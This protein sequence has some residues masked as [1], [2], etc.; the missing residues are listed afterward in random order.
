VSRTANIRPIVTNTFEGASTTVSISK[1]TE[2]R[3][4]V[5]TCMLWEREFYREGAETANRIRLLASNLPFEKVADLALEAREQY[6]LRHVPLWLLVSLIDSGHKGNQVSEAIAKVI[7]RPDEMSELL[8]L[9]WKDGKKPLTKQLKK[10]LAKA[11]KKFN[12]YSLAKFDK[13][14]A[15]S[16]RD[17]MFLSHPCPDSPE[18]EALFKRVANKELKTPDTWETQLSAGA[19]KGETFVRLIG[20]QKLGPQAM[21]KNLRNMINANVGS[22]AIRMGLKNVKTDRV[23]P[24]EFI[25]AA[26]CA[27]QFEPELEELMFKCLAG[28]SLKGKTTLLIDR[29]GSM[30][31]RLSDK[32]ELTRYDAAAGLAMLLREES[33][34]IRIFTFYSQSSGYY[35]GPVKNVVTEIPPRR[36]FAL[37]DALGTPQGGTYLGDAVKWVNNNAS[38]D[39]LIVLTDEQSADEVPGAAAKKSYMINVGTYEKSVGIGQWVRVAGWSEAIV[40]FIKAHEAQK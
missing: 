20:E 28:N 6:K 25:T 9:Y 14:G 31:D 1:E 10:G 22:D 11:F 37:R 12:E 17:V 18:Q 21:L 24:F 26:R 15:I 39:R 8:S 40:E 23:L 7:Q 2:L 16:L 34:D 38:S 5:L 32:S 29:S 13:P 35:G 3:R 4:A 27:K 30:N 36:G 19:N 33:S